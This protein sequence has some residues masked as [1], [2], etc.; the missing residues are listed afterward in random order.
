MNVFETA[1]KTQT[2]TPT[3][4]DENNNNNLLEKT[5]KIKKNAELTPA[6]ANEGEKQVKKKSTLEVPSQP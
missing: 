3:V 2:T 4:A 5:G 1:K 6:S